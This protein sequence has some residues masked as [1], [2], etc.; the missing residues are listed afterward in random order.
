MFNLHILNTKFGI[1][2]WPRVH[3]MY[4][5]KEFTVKNADYKA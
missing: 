1:G 5:A 4:I 2:Y 3:H